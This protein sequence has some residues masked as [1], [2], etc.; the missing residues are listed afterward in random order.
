M[1]GLRGVHTMMLSLQWIVHLAGLPKGMPGSSWAACGCKARRCANPTEVCP[2]LLRLRRGVWRLESMQAPL[3]DCQLAD[4]GLIRQY[5]RQVYHPHN[6]GRG[7][8]VGW[9]VVA[10]V[11]GCLQVGWSIAAQLQLVVYQCWWTWGCAGPSGASTA[12]PA[13]ATA[14]VVAGGKRTHQQLLLLRA[15]P[16]PAPAPCAVCDRRE[17]L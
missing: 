15:V 7:L 6:A 1:G 12:G 10:V 9:H 8:Y 13:V 17:R 5:S 3:C 16:C 4:A 2:Y 11:A 14:C